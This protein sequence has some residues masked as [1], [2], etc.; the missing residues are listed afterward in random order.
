MKNKLETL[1]SEIETTIRA[2]YA[3][4]CLNEL[5]R[6]QKN[7]DEA[8]KN[9]YFWKIFES[10]VLTKCFIGIRRLLENQSDTFCFQNFINNCK[11]NIEKFS[12]KELEQRKLNGAAVRPDYLDDYIKDAY[13]PEHNDFDLLAKFVKTNINRKKQHYLEIGSGI[14]AHAI[15]TDTITINAILSKI[16]FDEIEN[17]LNSIWCVYQAVW[18]MYENGHKPTLELRE[19]PYKDEV[20]SCIK[21]QL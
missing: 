9:V 4:R 21:V 20:Y 13:Q 10:S 1:R 14:F 15:H 8:N 7:V 17:M 11:T 16:E 19:Y 12:L 5:F 18:S 3:L 6:E 2:F